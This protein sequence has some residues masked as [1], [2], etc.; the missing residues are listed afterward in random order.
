MTTYTKNQIE[1]QNHI[2]AQNKKAQA[3]IDV[4]PDNRW[5]GM[6]T[7]DLDHWAEYKI[8]NVADYNRYMSAETL[9]EVFSSEYC[10]SYARSMDFFSMS[11]EELDS[12][13]NH[14]E[15]RQKKKEERKNSEY[16]E[17]LELEA[18]NFVNNKLLAESL[19]VTIDDLERWEVAY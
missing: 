11:Q 2:I 4:D 9:Y 7:T 10:K 14:I 5:Q 6:I 19:G 18:E 15:E 13:W 3:W 12:E 16:K 8:Y 1:L 17:I